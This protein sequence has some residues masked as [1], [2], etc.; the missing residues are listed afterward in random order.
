MD[1]EKA[2][3][4][5]LKQECGSA[6]TIKLEGMFKDMDLSEDVMQASSDTIHLTH[7]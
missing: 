5:K 7:I 2:M 3:V 4:S 6:F 1:T